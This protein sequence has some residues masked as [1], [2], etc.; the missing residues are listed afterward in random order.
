V[1]ARSTVDGR[2]YAVLSD[3][4]RRSAAGADLDILLFESTDNGITWSSARNVTANAPLDSDQLQPWITVDAAGRLHLAYADTRRT[5]GADP[6]STAQVRF[7][8]CAAANARLEGTDGVQ[9]LTLERLALAP[10]LPC[11]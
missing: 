5:T 9:T 8:S 6:A 4:T 10:A 3:V 2:L 1:F 11:D 7:D